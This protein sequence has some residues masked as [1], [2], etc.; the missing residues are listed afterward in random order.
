MGNWVSDF[1]GSIQN[2]TYRMF[3]KSINSVDLE[4]KSEKFWKCQGTKKIVRENQAI[5]FID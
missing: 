3:R 2:S 5:F 1:S 4:E